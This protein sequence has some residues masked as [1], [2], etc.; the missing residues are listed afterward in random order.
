VSVFEAIFL[1][2]WRKE[3]AGDKRATTVQLKYQ[4]FG[5]SR[6]GQGGIVIEY[7]GNCPSSGRLNGTNQLPKVIG[8]V[9]FRDG[10]EVVEVSANCAA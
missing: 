9:T 6:G 1:Q 4:E 8:G 7:V 10:I 3:M 2:L 5:A